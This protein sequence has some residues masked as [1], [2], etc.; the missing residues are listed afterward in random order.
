MSNQLLGP[1]L[2]FLFFEG[3]IS[4]SAKG[5]KSR[6]LRRFGYGLNS[7]CILSSIKCLY[8]A[9]FWSYGPLWD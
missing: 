2:F 9:W 7:A 1:G 4:G 5:V 6:F 3:S 8:G